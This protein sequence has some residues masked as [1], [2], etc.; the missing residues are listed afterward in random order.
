VAGLDPEI[1]RLIA[2][3]P[4][5][6][7]KATV[8]R[9]YLPPGEAVLFETRPSLWPYI[10]GGVIAGVLLAILGIILL[11]QGASLSNSTG[12]SSDGE[13]WLLVGG[14]LVALGI[15]IV[16][17]RLIGWYF[18]SY[19]LTNRRVIRKSG[20]G[21]R[22][23]V[24]ARFDKIQ[25]VTMTDTPRALTRKYGNILF[26]LSAG[27]HPFSGLQFGGIFWFA[28]PS[29]L[30]V[31]AFMEDVVETVARLERA[32]R[33]VMLMDLTRPSTFGPT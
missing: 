3:R 19:A 17:L 25:S 31:R 28:I 16:V 4:D 15:V 27:S 10:T 13:L 5:F 12:T 30:E 32:G 21:N 22:L 14:L 20:W 6:H 11:G 2:T 1:Q 26:S 24:D 9:E 18:S 23:V 8:P 29:P 7:Q 33:P